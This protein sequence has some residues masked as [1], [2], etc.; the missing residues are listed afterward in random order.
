M[1]NIKY[2]RKIAIGFQ[3]GTCPLKCKKCFAFGKNAPYKKEIG[4]MSIDNARR[5]LDEIS[6]FEIRP[7]IQPHIFTEPFANKDLME[8]IQYC[9]QKREGKAGLGMS[10]ITN[11]ILIDDEWERFILSELDENYTISFSLDAVTQS[12]Y[13]KVRGGGYNLI[14]IEDRIIN[15]IEKR[16]QRK[17]RIIVNYTIEEENEHEIKEFLEKWKYKVDAVGIATGVDANRRIPHL[18]RDNITNHYI[19]CPK[20]FDV[21]TIDYNG[22][23]RICQ[24]D[25]FGQTSFGNV[26]DHGI[27]NTWNGELINK[28]RQKHL[29]NTLEQEDYCFGCEGK[30]IADS[31]RDIIETEEFLIKKGTNVIFYNYKL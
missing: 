23:L 5:L 21:M 20:S 13:E 22:E 26:F 27:L 7:N 1:Y 12:T 25:A 6:T 18:Y 4:K 3:E 19:P 15:I 24:F 8:I 31:D 29:N 30:Y 11:G 16:K 9:N 14:D 10:I 17:P 28:I 2:P